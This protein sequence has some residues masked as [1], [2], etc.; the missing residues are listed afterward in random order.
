MRQ[1]A[2]DLNT[3]PQIEAPAQEAAGDEP[4][5]PP[6]PR[7]SIQA[8]CETETTANMLDVASQDRRLGRA[9]VT[10]QMGGVDAAVAFYG[11]A[12]TPNLIIIES[13]LQGDA[14][15]ADLG[16]LAEVCDAGT[17]VVVIGHINDVLLYRELMRSGVSEYL[18]APLEPLSVI[19]SIGGLYQDPDSEPLGR[20]IAFVG[21]KGGVGSSTIAH[22]TAWSIAEGYSSDVIIADL[23]LPFGTAALDFNQ[24]PPQ[25]IAEAVLSPERLDDVLLDRLLAKCSKHVSLFAAPSS[26]DQVYDIDPQA[27]DS[28][29]N[30]ARQNVPNIVL[31]VPHIWTGWARSVLLA[32]DDIV[33]TAVPDLANLRNAKNLLDLLKQNRPND[34]KPYILLNQ[35]G[36]PKRPEI[37]AKDFSEALDLDPVATIQFDPQL[38]GDAAN[39]G[40]MIQEMSA[41]SKP[42]ETFNHL[43]ALVTGHE[44]STVAKKSILGPILEKL[45]RKKG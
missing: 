19:N 3:D 34:R 5:V 35:V 16:R 32:A 23:D 14:M 9:H 41:G 40:Q 36:M 2:H 31:D 18:V 27:F 45:K 22:N 20:V 12:P 11:D 13:V 39:N 1:A 21:A 43:A 7:I 25:G 29:L 4:F 24:D 8:F 15:G 44:Q 42:A 10:V 17:K 33:V 26:L 38:F 6:V 30:V 37:S 28:V